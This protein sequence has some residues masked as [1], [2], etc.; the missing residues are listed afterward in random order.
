MTSD[1][2]KLKKFSVLLNEA[3]D[4][5]KSYKYKDI[6]FED[7]ADIISIQGAD[8]MFFIFPKD[9]IN[10]YY[11][12]T[13]LSILQYELAVKGIY[14]RGAI[15]SG[16]MYIDE[17][18]EIYYGEAWNKAVLSEQIAVNPRILIENSLARIVEDEMKKINESIL[19]FYLDI[20]G[21][22]VISSYNIYPILNLLKEN[23]PLK[24]SKSYYDMYFKE[25]FQ[26]LEYNIEKNI[27]N[28]KV[29]Q[30]YLW[31]L[32]QISNTEL[33][34]VKEVADRLKNKIIGI[35]VNM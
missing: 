35:L 17:E 12:I 1:I 19:E 34:E 6:L 27:S 4:N 5:M 24:D 33:H 3:I 21:V 32:N 22:Y 23:E 16:T 14:I 26:S 15:N 29:L 9:Y 20:D 11:M 30:K 28:R 25:L 18:K 13:R 10:T 8:S 31:I 2:T 7:K